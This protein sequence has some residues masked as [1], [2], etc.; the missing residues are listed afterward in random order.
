MTPPPAGAA[1]VGPWVDGER[2]YRCAPAAVGDAHVAVV[3]AQD[4]DGWTVSGVELSIPD[5]VTVAGRPIAVA[6]DL[7]VAQA[8]ELAAA[9]LAA[10]DD[11]QRRDGLVPPV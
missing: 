2:L 1:A 4:S 9:L 11:A 7:D 6:V 3:G 5:A 10:A 8:R